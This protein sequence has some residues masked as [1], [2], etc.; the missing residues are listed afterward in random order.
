MND[1]LFLGGFLLNVR[2]AWWVVIQLCAKLK[3]RLAKIM[4]A[5]TERLELNRDTW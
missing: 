5:I 1:I 3:S 2:R 4:S